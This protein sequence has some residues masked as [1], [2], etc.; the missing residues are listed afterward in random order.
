[1]GKE[2][3]VNALGQRI[4]K[5]HGDIFKCLDAVYDSIFTENVPREDD[6]YFYGRGLAAMMKLPKMSTNAASTCCLQINADGSIFINLSGIE[7]GQGVHTVFSQIAA[8]AM[9]IP[10]CKIKVYKDVDTQFSPWEWQTVASMQ[11]YRGGRAIQDAC[12]RVIELLKYNASLVWSA[13]PM[14]EHPIVAVAPCILNAIY[15]AIGVEFTGLPVLPSDIL[16]SI[17][18]KE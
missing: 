13:M 4:T 9:N 15:D 1:M 14:V 6:D 5:H 10:V 2:G 7:M 16:G 11:T 12:R 18:R 3:K 8:E 17:D